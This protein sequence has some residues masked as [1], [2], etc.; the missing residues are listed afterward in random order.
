M[1]DVAEIARLPFFVERR[2][3]FYPQCHDRNIKIAPGKGFF[4][5][6]LIPIVLKLIV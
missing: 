3:Y 5:K 1:I 4:H 2:K 6:V